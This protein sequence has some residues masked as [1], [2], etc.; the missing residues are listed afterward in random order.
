MRKDLDKVV[1]ERE[2][3]A[4]KER[5]VSTGWHSNRYD[6]EADEDRVSLPKHGRMGMYDREVGINKDFSDNLRPLIR[7]ANAQV[8]RPWSKVFSEIRKSFPHN[9]LNDHLIYTHLLGYF[10]IGEKL[11]NE[12]EARVF[13]KSNNKTY[14]KIYRKPRYGGKAYE[15]FYGDIY[16]DPDSD[17][18]CRYS[19]GKL[20]TWAYRKGKPTTT[21]TGFPLNADRDAITLSQEDG[22]KNVIQFI[23]GI[24]YRIVYDEL[25]GELVRYP[26]GISYRQKPTFAIRVKKQLN[27]KELKFYGVA[28]S[29]EKK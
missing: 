23:D 28:N 13:T 17:I 10:N 21:S 3:R 15:I 7:W 18:I 9:K 11:D 1:T 25:E 5:N 14:R 22:V 16:V 4:S 27:K 2:R 24:W 8:G 29:Q 6:A 20:K 26:S 12:I 19:K